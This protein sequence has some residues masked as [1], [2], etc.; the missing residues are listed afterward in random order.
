MS[1][2]DSGVSPIADVYHEEQRGPGAR[3]RV[4]ARWVV[5]VLAVVAVLVGSV[6]VTLSRYH[7]AD[8]NKDGKFSL[9]E[10]TR[11]IELFNTRAGTART[12]AY[13]V[14]AGTEDG[15]GPGP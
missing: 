2:G 6:V 4:R 10:L 7:S 13:H 3:R 15:F 12:G 14:Q 1:T 11:V 8:A 5:A 9:T